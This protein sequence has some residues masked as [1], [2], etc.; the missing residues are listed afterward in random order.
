VPLLPPY[1]LTL[2]IC[3]FLCPFVYNTLHI[4]PTPSYSY[5][6]TLLYFLGGFCQFFTTN[7]TSLLLL[8]SYKASVYWTH[9]RTT[10]QRNPCLCRTLRYASLPH[11]TKLKKEQNYRGGG[12]GGGEIEEI[13]NFVLLFRI[14]LSLS[15]YPHF[16]EER[17]W[18]IIKRKDPKHGW[19]S[20]L[21]GLCFWRQ[22]RLPPYC[23]RARRHG[24]KYSHVFLLFFFWL[25]PV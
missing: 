23:A 1:N 5:F 20:A 25:D 16:L 8:P 13:G 11:S 3:L 7:S 6:P 14:C 19:Q 24:F 12:G 21:T 10:R 17:G 15:I 18:G 22:Q 9:G 2:L 4:L